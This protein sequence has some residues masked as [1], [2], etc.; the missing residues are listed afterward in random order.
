[1]QSTEPDI[2]SQHESQYLRTKKS[3]PRAASRDVYPTLATRRF[4][5]RPFMLSDV[6][7]LAA[8]AGEHRVADTTIGI[9]HPYTKEFARKW[10]SSHSPPQERCL[11][12]HW[13]AIK[14]GDDRIVGY[15]GLDKID[16]ERRQA[17][18]RFWVG[19]GV[20]RARDA[21]EWSKAIVEYAL[22]RLNLERIYAL[23]LAR[24]PLAGRVL[25]TIGMRREGLV[26]KCICNGGVM[27]DLVCWGT[28]RHDWRQ[29]PEC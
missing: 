21:I 9:P 15:A 13:A 10:I 20:Q 29:H 8:L 12:L 16:V 4:E 22:S 18:L 27:E 17:E 3:E 14:L 11:G 23:Q 2:L 1:M 5:F 19:C 24:H 7:R 26:R 25:A 6:G 28:R